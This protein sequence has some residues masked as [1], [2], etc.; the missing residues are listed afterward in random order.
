M[1]HEEKESQPQPAVASMRGTTAIDMLRSNY[2]S[3]SG[4]MFFQRQALF[5][6]RGGL[7]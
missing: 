3:N 7:R 5:T 1:V 2:D 6:P 4:L